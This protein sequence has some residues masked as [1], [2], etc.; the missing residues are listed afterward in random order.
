M[1][2]TRTAKDAGLC[3]I[4][5]VA[6]GLGAVAPPAAPAGP[7]GPEHQACQRA[8]ASLRATQCWTRVTLRTCPCLPVP[9]FGASVAPA[10]HDQACAALRA[11]AYWGPGGQ[12]DPQESTGWR[13]TP[14]SHPL[15]CCPCPF[16]VLLATGI[17]EIPGKIYSVDSAEKLT[18]PPGPLSGPRTESGLSFQGTMGQQCEFLPCFCR[19]HDGFCCSGQCP[20]P[21]SW[22]CACLGQEAGIKVKV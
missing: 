16:W 11:P 2:V 6:S 4:G 9:I 21:D 10:G 18:Y 8:G 5:R 13:R 7:G 3:P 12:A 15:W 20:H 1:A 22:P 19:L 17:G 14:L